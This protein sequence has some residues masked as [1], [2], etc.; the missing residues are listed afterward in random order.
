MAA[1]YFSAEEFETR[2]SGGTGLALVDFWADWCGPCK[3]LGPTI[4]ELADE[5]QDSVLVGKVNIE[6][7][8]ELATRFDV[9]SI[10]TI[11]LFRDGQEIDRIVGLVPKQ[12]FLDLIESAK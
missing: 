12:R 11:I 5:L 8:G 10:P 7:A 3:M 9:M 2:V 1:T 4:E 6:E